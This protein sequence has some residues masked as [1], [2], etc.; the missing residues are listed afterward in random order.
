MLVGA[1]LA[2]A[3]GHDRPARLVQEEP[4]SADALVRVVDDS[5]VTAADYVGPAPCGECHPDK[6]DGWGRGLHRSMNQL[7]AGDAS[8]RG[9]VRGDFSEPYRYAGA[10]VRFGRAEMSLWR[11]QA[12]VRRFRI[13]RTIGSRYLQEYVG[14]QVDGPESPG[15]PIYATEIRLPFGYWITER[16]WFHQQYYDSWYGA[17]Y[18]ADGRPAIDPFAVEPSPWAARC[19]WCHNTYPFEL[20]LWRDD[21]VGH[22]LEQFV[23]LAGGR[24]PIADN[25]LPVDRLVTVGVSCESCHL[26]GRAHAVDGR[27]IRFDPVGRHVVARP[28]APD[29]SGGRRSATVINAICAQCHSTPSPHYPSGAATR[30]STEALDLAAS[31]CPVKCTDCHDPHQTGPGAGAPDDPRHIAACTRCHG[32][33]VGPGAARAHSGHTRAT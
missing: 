6:L 19:A 13:T 15:D 7:V 28:G 5:N 33:L 27:P 3:C 26:G 22:G 4:G 17:E 21:D 24:E 31:P 23:T 1:L 30:N 2:A 18:D 20:R 25:L 8:D 32:A 29:L 16:R 10:E 9:V 12:L 11:G 14:I